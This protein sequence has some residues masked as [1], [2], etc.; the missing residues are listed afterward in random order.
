VTASPVLL[1][2]A[3]AIRRIP[4]LLVP[5]GAFCDSGPLVAEALLELDRETG[6][7]QTS[8]DPQDDNDSS[9]TVVLLGTEH[10]STARHFLSLAGFSQ[11]RTPLGDMTV[12]PEL[13][14]QIA[15]TILPVETEPFLQEHSI[16]NQLPFLQYLEQTRGLSS[17]NILPISV[18]S[19]VTEDDF[20]FLQQQDKGPLVELA[21]LLQDYQGHHNKRIAVLATTDYHHVGPA[22]G[23][24]PPGWGRPND[25]TAA[26]SI[27]SIPDYIRQLDAPLLEAIQNTHTNN[28]VVDR[29]YRTCQ[30]SSMCGLG[31]TLVWL[32]LKQL[33]DQ[34]QVGEVQQPTTHHPVHNTYPRLLRHIVGS[35]IGPH[36]DNQTGFA[37]FLML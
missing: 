29:V 3:A 24:V 14:Q 4:F 23:V 33:L 9:R 26:Y 15:A 13:F 21:Q 16:E 34:E 20:K 17:L 30:Y 19:V 7:F 27:L 2:A 22:Y 12:D 18:R 28:N 10:A 37:T 31:A 5:H 32:R 25:D 35:D 11:W 1:P 8:S 36:H 6:Y